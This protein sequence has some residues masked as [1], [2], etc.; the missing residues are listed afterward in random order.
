[1]GIF[2]AINDAMICICLGDVYDICILVMEYI[3]VI[4]Y[5]CIIK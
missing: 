3:Y 5:I 4:S 1:M 2:N